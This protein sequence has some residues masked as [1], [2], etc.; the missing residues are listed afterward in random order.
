MTSWYDIDLTVDLA[1]VTLSFKILSRLYISE[2][3]RCRKLKLDRNISWGYRYAT[4]CCD[5]DVTF[6][7]AVVPLS[8]KI[9]SG[10]YLGNRKV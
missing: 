2:T 5:L 10:L 4:S 6:D 1:V 3:I 7:L 8:F 9:L